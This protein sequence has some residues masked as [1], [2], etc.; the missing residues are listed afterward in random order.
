MGKIIINEGQYKRLFLLEQ[1]S[2]YDKPY[3]G[4]NINFRGY[5]PDEDG[6]EEG[7][8]VEVGG[9][10]KGNLGIDTPYKSNKLNDRGQG[11][12]LDTWVNGYRDD[13]PTGSKLK[14]IIEDDSLFYLNN[15]LDKIF[16]K[17]LSGK[18]KGWSNLTQH[19]KN[20]LKR[21]AF[22]DYVLNADKNE[23]VSLFRG[24]ADGG[25]PYWMLLSDKNVPR[26]LG[27]YSNLYNKIKGGGST[28]I[29][30]FYIGGNMLGNSETKKRYDIS[31]GDYEYK[32]IK[33]V[34]PGFIYTYKGDTKYEYAVWNNEW[35]Y[36]TK[37][38]DDEWE[39]VMNTDSERKLDIAHPNVRKDNETHNNE[40]R[41]Q[42]QLKDEKEF[43]EQYGGNIQTEEEA[44]Y[45]LKELDDLKDY[46]NI[47]GCGDCANI[48]IAGVPRPNGRC[49]GCQMDIK[50]VISAEAM[51]ELNAGAIKGC[52]EKT[53]KYIKEYDI[54]PYAYTKIWGTYNS[55]PNQYT[56][57]SGKGCSYFEAF[58]EYYGTL[59]INYAKSNIKEYSRRIRGVLAPI[60]TKPVTCTIGS[61]KITFSDDAHPYEGEANT[62][63]KVITGIGNFFSECASDYHCVL[64][65]A[66]IAALAV[67]GAGIFISAA[68]DAANSGSYF[69]EASQLKGSERSWA[70]AGGGLTLLGVIPGVSRA[71]KMVRGSD[72]A[73]K[74]VLTKIGKEVGKKEGKVIGSE[75]DR[76]LE[77]AVVGLTVKQ[78]KELMEILNAIVKVGPEMKSTIS[79]LKKLTPNQWVDLNE[80]IKNEKSFKK[81]IDVTKSETYK[82]GNLLLAL[83][84]YIK[85]K[86]GKDALTQAGLFT[87]LYAALPPLVEYGVESYKNMVRLRNKDMTLGE[88]IDYDGWNFD[89][90]IKNFKSDRGGR[91]NGLLWD[92]WK[93]GWRP[94]KVDGDG[95]PV[96]VKNGNPVLN[97][98]PP[99]YRTEL[100]QEWWEEEEKNREK[101]KKQKQE[102]DKENLEGSET[103]EN[104]K[105][106]IADEVN[107]K[108]DKV[109]YKNYYENLWLEMKK[110]NDDA[111]NKTN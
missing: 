33:G 20:V 93:D 42:N 67:P 66:S 19:E 72:K 49:M 23:R 101:I 35:Y 8:K 69:Y 65:V 61:C 102:I 4:G 63:T 12:Y 40:L 111:K 79:G 2:G 74:E 62:L 51:E 98:V 87:G 27:M 91:D 28:P 90:V 86:A 80:F 92:A 14:K 6:K 22:D 57:C 83:Q 44:Y 109:A 45:A 18:E 1:R 85:T 50:T 11:W 48:K 34:N 47:T 75:M 26:T 5:K 41:Y 81:Y 53:Q 36:S 32:M 70:L 84:K 9:G 58:Q 88:M 71:V 38:I 94:Y 89:D 3:K 60:T 73:V 64:D 105:R 31:Q 17:V 15:D 95:N 106:K 77:D 46:I 99:N 52:V 37:G 13:D 54:P 68:I 108:E 55:W 30:S 104:L 43:T 78:E 96:N 59:N 25:D 107:R 10:D 21:F 7:R 56:P 100:Y 29:P 82:N 103:G 110:L 76:I 97:I 39:R 24:A 16:K